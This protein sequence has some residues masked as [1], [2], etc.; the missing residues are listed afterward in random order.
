MKKLDSIECNIYV[1]QSERREEKLKC[2]ECDFKCKK[3]FTIQ[4]HMSTKHSVMVRKSG[5][6]RYRYYKK[7]HHIYR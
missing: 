5:Q 2:N 1:E 7:Q 3:Q 6:A 4:R